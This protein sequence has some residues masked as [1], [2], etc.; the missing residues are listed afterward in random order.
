MIQVAQATQQMKI[1]NYLGHCVLEL[2]CN[3]LFGP[4]KGVSG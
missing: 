3:S 1:S 2:G 4:P